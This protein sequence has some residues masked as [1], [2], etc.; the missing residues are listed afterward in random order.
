[1]LPL[2]LIAGF[3]AM[4]SPALAI[5]DISPRGMALKHELLDSTMT[6]QPLQLIARTDDGKLKVVQES[7]EFIVDNASCNCPSAIS[8]HR[9]C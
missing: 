4:A 1:M 9:L 7:I 6:P 3:M 8:Q 5:N 2:P